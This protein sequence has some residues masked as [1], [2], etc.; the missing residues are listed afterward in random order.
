MIP[1]SRALVATLAGALLL[2]ATG[3]ISTPPAGYR[4]VAVD[5]PEF[6]AAV[7]RE[8]AAEVRAGKSQADAEAFATR[9]VRKQTIEA[10]KLRRSDSVEPLL[11]ALDA[12]DKPRGCWAY[13]VTSTRQQNATTTVLVERFDPFLPE[14]RIWTLVTQDGIAPTDDEQA[15]YRRTRLAQWKKQ[16]A[17]A[18]K[19]RSAAERSGRR[20]LLVDSVEV[21]RAEAGSPTVFSFV[22]NERRGPLLGELPGTQETYAV[23]ESVSR[24]TN[25]RRTHLGSYSI[26]G[27]S[28]QVEHW[29]QS[30]SYAMVDPNVAPFP[31]S[32]HV[33]FRIRSFG[34]DT[35]DVSIASTFSD[36]K[37]VKCYDDRFEVQIGI[38]SVQDY[39]PAAK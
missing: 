38:P 28:V 7:T 21:T 10:E 20:A 31:A 16:S 29:D 12:R 5:T 32:S 35:G 4:Q 15:T 27:G 1:V 33:S 2:G 18:A 19:N 14:A 34:T 9:R 25:H 36:Y 39:I 30:T 24:L 22:N 6:K 37:R 17:A 23:D 8:A 26:L 3:C 13:T 11:R